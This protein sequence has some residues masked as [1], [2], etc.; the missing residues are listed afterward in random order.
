MLCKR[1]KRKRRYDKSITAAIVFFDLTKAYD[2][3]ER[4]IFIE[5]LLNYNIPVNIVLIIKNMLENFTLKYEGQEIE[6]KTQRDLVQ[7][8]VLSSLLFNLYINDLI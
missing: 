2:M 3:V 4:A 6:I 7:G 8:L 1:T 5:K